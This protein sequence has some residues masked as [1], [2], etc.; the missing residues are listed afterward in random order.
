M[1]S[2]DEPLATSEGLSAAGSSGLPSRP[3]R[4]VAFGCH[5][6][7]GLEGLGVLRAG[8][9]SREDAVE[10]ARCERFGGRKWM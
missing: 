3:A 5:L 9:G 6:L 4:L 8:G 2:G 10:N 7:L 1:L